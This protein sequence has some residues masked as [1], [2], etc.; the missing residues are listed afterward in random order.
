M[1]MGAELLLRLI[2]KSEI[3][4]EHDLREHEPFIHLLLVCSFVMLP[5]V[6]LSVLNSFG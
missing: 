6:L 2:S 4:T 5:R 3:G 1:M